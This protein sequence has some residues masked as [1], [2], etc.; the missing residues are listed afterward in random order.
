MLRYQRPTPDQFRIIKELRR[1]TK[2]SGIFR[3]GVRARLKN[4]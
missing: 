4:A 3:M 1:I 2:K